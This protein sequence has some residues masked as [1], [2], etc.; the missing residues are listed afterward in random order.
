MPGTA[1]ARS[2]HR[3]AGWN[4]RKQAFGVPA[5]ELASGTGHSIGTSQQILDTYNPLS[6][7]AAKSA[8]DK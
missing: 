5:Y 4:S 7:D 2:G 6:Y 3:Q 1:S 8:Q